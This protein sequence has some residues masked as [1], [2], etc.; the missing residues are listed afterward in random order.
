MTQEQID[1][2]KRLCDYSYNL[3]RKNREAE[4][5]AEKAWLDASKNCDH[6]YP[7][8]STA[9]ESGFLMNVCKI[10]HESDY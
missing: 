5:Q 10:C 7:D 9:V 1:N 3:P 2:L 6:K 8:G 4:A